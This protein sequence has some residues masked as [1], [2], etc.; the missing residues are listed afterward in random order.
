MAFNVLLFVCKNN[1]IYN[2]YTDIHGYPTR[3]TIHQIGVALL[4]FIV[5]ECVSISIGRMEYDSDKKEG[6]T[7]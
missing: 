1:E 4:D 7:K 6:C 5:S 3:E 2:S